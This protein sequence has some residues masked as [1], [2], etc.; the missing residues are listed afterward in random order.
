MPPESTAQVTAR[1]SEGL[2]QRV[3]GSAGVGTWI[4]N[5]VC[6]EVTDLENTAKLHGLQDAARVEEF[7]AA[8]YP[9][10]RVTVDSSVIAARNTGRLE[11]EYRV[12]SQDGSMRRLRSTGS[13]LPQQDGQPARMAGVVIDVTEGDH[14][15]DVRSRLAAIVDSSDDAI[16][17]KDL[18]GIV[19]SWNAGATHL[20]GYRPEEIIGK[21]IL[22]IIPPELHSDEPRIIETLRSGKRVD[23]YETVRVRKDG[24]R[25][26]VALTISPVRDS[27]GR[28]VGASKIARDIG[29][30]LRM[31]EAMIESEKLAATGRMAAA[32]AHEINNPLEAVTN[33]AYLISTDPGLSDAGKKYADLL[34]EEIGRVSQVAKQ[35]LGFFRDS[36]KPSPFDACELLDTVV[37]LYRPLLEKNG[38]EVIRDFEGSCQVFGSS[39]EIRQVFANL[40]RN[41]IEA[42]GPQGVIQLRVRTCS[43]GMRR[44]LVAD[45]GHGISKETRRRLFQP[46]VTSKGTAGNGLG[47]WVSQGIVKKHGGRIQVK[48]CEGSGRSG[49]VF[50]VLLPVWEGGGSDPLPRLQS[51]ALLHER[52]AP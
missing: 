10:D 7:L 51:R 11:T 45:N 37:N 38:I 48:T 21:S 50:S 18:N 40:V 3:L 20:F 23:H 35:S 33:L 32:I 26:Q 29:E 19:T 5:P 2:L 28:I 12:V 39:S 14:F 15:D 49:T 13:L 34:L 36:K 27:Q 42:V 4:W 25:V 9:E 1:E 43:S 30:R 22:T 17:S 31:Q 24:E 8:V 41:A 16:I 46:F 47:L 44:I 6:N 52:V